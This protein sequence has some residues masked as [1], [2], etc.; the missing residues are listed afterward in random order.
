[1]NIGEKRKKMEANVSFL[2]AIR[3]NDTPPFELF[4]ILTEIL[5]HKCAIFCNQNP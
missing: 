4:R 2:S 1:M 3:K 5:Y